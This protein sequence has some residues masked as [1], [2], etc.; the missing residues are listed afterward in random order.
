MISV[1]SPAMRLHYPERKSVQWVHFISKPRRDKEQL[2]AE[3]FGILDRAVWA[4]NGR[5]SN[6]RRSNNN[7]V[8]SFSGNGIAKCDKSS[9]KSGEERSTTKVAPHGQSN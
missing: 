2:N 8:G 9:E 3:I 4:V 6:L 5:C 1:Y 7:N